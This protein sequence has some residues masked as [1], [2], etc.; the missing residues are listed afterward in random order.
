MIVVAVVGNDRK[1]SC[2]HY[3]NKNRRE[4]GILDREKMR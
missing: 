3:E 1:R 4:V 2:T